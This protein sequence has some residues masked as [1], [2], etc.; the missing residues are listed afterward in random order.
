MQPVVLHRLML[1][2]EVEG[3]LRI[4]FGVNRKISQ[5]IREKTDKYQ[6]LSII[7]PHKMIFLSNCFD[8]YLFMFNFVL[9]M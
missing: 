8:D 4:C 5:V 7:E 6:W 9:L 1:V 3:R 2:T